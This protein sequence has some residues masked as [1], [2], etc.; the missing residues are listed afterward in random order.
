MVRLD[1]ARDVLLPS[2]VV[3]EVRGSPIESINVAPVKSCGDLRRRVP[4]DREL[5]FM[6]DRP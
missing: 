3:R 5:N 1:V 6:K 2:V 4:L